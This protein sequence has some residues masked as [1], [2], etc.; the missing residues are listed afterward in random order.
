M[1]VLFLAPYP[2]NESPSQRYRFEHYLSSLSSFGIEY[3]YRPFLDIDTWQIFFTPGNYGR[4]I[5]GLIKGFFRRWLLMCTIGE[6]DFV[7][8]HRE[9]APLGPPLFEWIIAKIWRKKLY[10]FLMMLSGYRL[11]R[12]IIR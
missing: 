11:H 6:Y 2:A 9:A 3:D 1:N 5:A 8:I 7:Y 4:K 12:R 10:M